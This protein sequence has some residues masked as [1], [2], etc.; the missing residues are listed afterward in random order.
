MKKLTLHAVQVEPDGFNNVWKGE[1]NKVGKFLPDDI[2]YETTFSHFPD[3][4]DYSG[5]KEQ[6][7]DGYDVSENWLR[8]VFQDI[9]ANVI[10]VHLS[11]DQWKKMGLPE[12]L[13]GQSQ[14]VGNTAV[15]YGRWS[16]RSTYTPS[17]NFAD[18]FNE[19][20][21]Q[22]IGIAH[23]ISHGLYDILNPTEEDRTHYH[24]YG[25]EDTDSTKRY[26]RTPT[27][28]KAFEQLNWDKLPQFHNH[29]DEQAY[30]SRDP[31]D[32]HPELRKRWFFLKQEWDANHDTNVKLSCTYRNKT[33]QMQEFKGGDSKARWK[34]SLHNYQP[35]YALDFYI[36][37]NGK[38]LWDTS[39]YEEMAR[40]AEAIGLESLI[41][42][43]DGTHLQLPMTYHDAQEGRIPE[44]PDL[45]QFQYGLIK[46][47]ATKTI[48]LL[49]QLL[50]KK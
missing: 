3:L 8:K 24:F 16:N 27:P 6:K 48:D 45:K 39:Y 36:E 5:W 15:C 43:A 17:E 11:L 31:A 20:P 41:D 34:E 44:L 18:P 4:F 32:L 46:Q 13:W 29:A 37:D 49:W 35:S 40:E 33:A 26:V 47:L 14:D 30:T 25:L 10:Y 28:K 9:D 50:G 2:E 22:T 7:D 12:D 23:E 1:V 21:E 38:A 19:F 42:Q